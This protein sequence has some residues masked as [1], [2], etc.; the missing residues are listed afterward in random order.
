MSGSEARGRE[1]SCLLRRRRS[2]CGDYGFVKLGTLFGTDASH[3]QEGD[4]AAGDTSVGF[5][6]FRTSHLNWYF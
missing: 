6:P 5:G 1:Q 4:L 2:V 3:R